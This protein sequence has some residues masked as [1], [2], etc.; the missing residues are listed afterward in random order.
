[1]YRQKNYLQAEQ[2]TLEDGINK[3]AGDWGML[4]GYR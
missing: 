4:H 2:I 1:M 3:V